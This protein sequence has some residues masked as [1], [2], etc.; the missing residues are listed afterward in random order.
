MLK[1][2]DIFELK[3][4]DIREPLIYCVMNTISGNCYIGQTKQGLLDRFVFSPRSHKN[5]LN[6]GY[7]NS[8]YQDIREFGIDNYE[9]YILDMYTSHD[10]D[11]NERFYIKEFDSYDRGLNETPG[12]KTFSRSAWEHA[13]GA[14]AKVCRANQSGSFFNP[15]EHDRVCRLGGSAKSED[16]VCR[17][18]Q[19]CKD[20]SLEV[21]EE[22]Y[23]FA[24]SKVGYHNSPSWGT[25]Q[26]NY[27]WLH[28]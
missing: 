3:V 23:R 6:E 10:L 8:L 20:N 4:E 9:V 13:K 26:R 16:D 5:R 24:R 14:S 21:N 2:R 19:Y 15:D 7:Q 17:I 22:N 28:L 27:S 25:Y 18:L 1:L 12:G 11:W